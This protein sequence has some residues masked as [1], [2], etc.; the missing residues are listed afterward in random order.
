MRI[1]LDLDSAKIH[2]GRGIGF[3]AQK[4]HQSLTKRVRPLRTDPFEVVELTNKSSKKLDLI[5]YPGF[6]LFK[7]PQQIPNTP[8]VVTVHDLIPLDYPK[9]FPLGI[10]GKLA[11]YLQKK[12]L[13]KARAIITDSNASKESIQKHTNISNQKIHVIYL[14][15]DKEFTTLNDQIRL[16]NLKK[17]YNLPDKFVLYVGDFNWNKNI[18]L[19][20]QTCIDLKYPLVIV[21]KKALSD[22]FDQGHSE[23]H[24]LVKFQQLAKANSK[25][26]IRL[27]YLPTHDLVTIYNLATVFAYPSK[28]EGFGLPIL[29]AFSCGCPVITSKFTSTAEISG[30]AAILIDPTNLNEL[31][32]AL[33]DIWTQPALREKLSKLG[34]NQVKKFTWDK[35]IKQT[36]DV[37]QKVLS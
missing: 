32:K 20:T 24:D 18:P 22:D 7:F 10:K 15:A 30:K 23:N 34:L 1:A 37:Y 36:Y 3:Y 28:A 31:K 14:A 17:Q 21:G 5:H 6:T 12:W 13:K 19:L 2:K 35:T 8:F 9:H 26:I 16:N 25:T 29:E 33:K 27:G 11:W 4:L